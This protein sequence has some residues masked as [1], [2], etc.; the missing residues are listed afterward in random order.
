MKVV[1]VLRSEEKHEFH[2]ISITL[3][4]W[5]CMNSPF[6]LNTVSSSKLYCQWVGEGLE[7]RSHMGSG[8]HAEDRPFV[9]WDDHLLHVL[10]PVF[11][12]CF[13]SYF[14]SYLIKAKMPKEKM[15]SSVK[16]VK[17]TE[18]LQWNHCNHQKSTLG[19]SSILTHWHLSDKI[20]TITTSVPRDHTL[21]CWMGKTGYILCS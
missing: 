17:R 21:V 6:M 16:R 20:N 9:W 7:S 18:S 1:C 13:L 8:P 19:P 3:S 2:F 14:Q 12:P 5:Q 15:I 4:V 11:S 10:F